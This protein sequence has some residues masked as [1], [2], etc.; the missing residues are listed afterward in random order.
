MQIFDKC[1]ANFTIESTLPEPANLDYVGNIIGGLQIESDTKSLEL[2][3]EKIG[4]TLILKNLACRYVGLF[5]SFYNYLDGYDWD[6]GQ[7]FDTSFTVSNW[8]C[9]IDAKDA[10]LEDY[11]GGFTGYLRSYDSDVI[12]NNGYIAIDTDITW[13]QD[14]Y[15]DLYPII[16]SASDRLFVNSLYL[17]IDKYLGVRADARYVGKTTKELMQQET[18]PGWDFDDVWIMRENIDY[19]RLVL[20]KKLAL[21]TCKKVP[22]NNYRR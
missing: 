14:D 10:N 2:S 1:V 17:D 9:E 5:G 19:P 8:Y 12:I 3:A 22:L 13:N 6:T 7:S 4:G 16:G 20:L 21:I 11:L 15:Y 18:F